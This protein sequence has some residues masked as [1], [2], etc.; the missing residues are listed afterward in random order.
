M[1]QISKFLEKYP[2]ETCSVYLISYLN[3]NWR[4]RDFTL[5][6]N[7]IP[8][9]FAGA[10]P[11]TPKEKQGSIYPGDRK[12]VKDNTLS[13]QIRKIGIQDADG[14]KIIEDLPVITVF[15]PS[16]MGGDWLIQDQGKKK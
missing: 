6:N 3:G 13:I 7:E 16:K 10:Y 11:V 9:L 4:Q 15:V 5:V 14:N 12:I 2:D 1:L 8:N